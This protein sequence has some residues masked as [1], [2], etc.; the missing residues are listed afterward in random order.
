MGENLSP[1]ADILFRLYQGLVITDLRG[2]R[3][4]LETVNN[5]RSFRVRRAGPYEVGA[6]ENLYIFDTTS[7]IKRTEDDIQSLHGLHIIQAQELTK[8]S[9][10]VASSSFH[11]ML[12]SD[13]DS[14]LKRDDPSLDQIF[15]NPQKYVNDFA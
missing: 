9:S 10:S 7:Q 8:N 15:D 4:T 2:L 11:M 6:G 13:V 1:A 5:G 14:P 12:R 3:L